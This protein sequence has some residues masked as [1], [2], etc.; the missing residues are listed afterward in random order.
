VA[1]FE[2]HTSWVSV[3]KSQPW[4]S[5]TGLSR[6]ICQASWSAPPVGGV[7]GFNRGAGNT[8]SL[9]WSPHSPDTSHCA[10][11]ETAA[12]ELLTFFT[13]REGGTRAERDGT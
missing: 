12:K 6:V 7:D 5:R 1:S 4:M 3:T 8:W 11:G 9:F 10:S 13:A 2:A